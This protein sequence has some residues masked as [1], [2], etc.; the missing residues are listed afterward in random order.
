MSLRQQPHLR[1]LLL[2]ALLSTAC[3]GGSADSGGDQGPPSNSDSTPPFTSADPIGGLYPE[4]QVVTLT[5][6]EPATVYYTTDGFTP[7]VGGVTTISG[8]SPITGIL[9]NHPL[10]LKFFA[11]DDAGNQESVKTWNYDFDLD[12]P[13]IL[14]SDF[15]TGTYGLFETLEVKFASDE[16]G[17][18]GVEIGG[19]G[20]PGSGT[21]VNTGFSVAFQLINV[22]LP[23]WRL[24][25]NR[26][27]EGN[28]V[29]AY[30]ADQAGG[31]AS[32]E[33][34]IKTLA[35]GTIPASG[36][37]IADLELTPDGKWGYALRPALS[38]V[39]K[40]DAD[41]ESVTFNQFVQFIN[42]G[43]NPTSMALT[44]NGLRLYV[45]HDGGFSEVAVSTDMVTPIDMP[46]GQDPSGIAMQPDALVALV[47]AS[48][49]SFWQLDVDP[50]SRD[51]R[52]STQLVFSEPLMTAAEI[53]MA[54]AGDK[55]IVTWTGN[56]M[57]GV[58]VLDTDPASP[59]YLTQP[60]EL[61]EAPEP[62]VIAS[63]VI[64][65][66]SSRAWVGNDQGMIQRVFLDQDPPN[67]VNA[68]LSLTMRGV[69][70]MPSEEYLLLTGGPLDGIR[71]VD[72]VTLM[73]VHM[74]EAEGASGT[75]TGRQI[76]YS[77]DGKR[78][79]LVRDNDSATAEV[80]MLWLTSE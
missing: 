29:W 24:A 8:P 40:F 19:T 9:I 26:P 1:P 38:Q 57:Y 43:A 71:F 47:A 15:L 34:E 3:G 77:P 45:T 74:L 46:G 41:P 65:A 69:T 80:W 5:A 12:P 17:P 28:S 14:I 22:P 25:P 20:D 76:R 44:P 52:T 54:P 78:M 68:S 30:V 2:L 79:Y 61:F 53:A 63:A 35:E 60:A 56:G 62:P 66:D 48:D 10:A 16:N 4:H 75:G 23:V 73:L 13:S 51:Y 42:V 36:G 7:T 55:A 58:A 21:N 64:S 67:L 50:G 18:W 49:G 59:G 33:F 72:P 37:E 6:N 27:S 11:V 31:L 39:W 32:Y 70:L